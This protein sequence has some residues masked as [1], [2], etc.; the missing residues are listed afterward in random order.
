MKKDYLGNE[1]KIGDK[2]VFMQ[3]GYR[4]LMVGTIVS[5]SNQKAKIT[6]EKTNVGKTETLQFFHQLIKHP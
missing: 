5:M 4:G 3:I 6:H 2:V 1:I